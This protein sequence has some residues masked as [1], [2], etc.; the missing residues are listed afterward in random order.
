MPKQPRKVQ[1][2]KEKKA[3]APVNKKPPVG[4]ASDKPLPWPV[5]VGFRIV[6]GLGGLGLIA[7]VIVGE[8]KDHEETMASYIGHG[9]YIGIGVLLMLV[10]FRG[11]TRTAAFAKGIA[12]AWKSKG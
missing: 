2:V 4:T 8:M 3:P 11:L 12:T 5:E 1:P 6:M 9:L 10:A 7:I